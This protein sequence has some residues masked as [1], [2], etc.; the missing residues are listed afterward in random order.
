MPD[1]KRWSRDEIARMRREMD[2]LFDELCT[3]FDLP[4]MVCR[5]AGDLCL[6]DEKDILVV[7]L[8]LG[9]MNPDNVKISV[10]NRQLVISAECARETG[11]LLE[12]QSFRR[13]L[14][15]PCDINADGVEVELMN[16]TLEVRLP[17][18]PAKQGQ[19]VKIIKK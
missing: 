16:G 12:S 7:R 17:K 6:K 19:T 1:L 4:V 8:E 11:K 13:E 5:M 14:S 10:Q 15:L 18:S 3:D 9:N 2:R